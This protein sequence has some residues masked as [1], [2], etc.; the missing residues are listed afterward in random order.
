MADK[1]PTYSAVKSV[2]KTQ[3]KIQIPIWFIRQHGHEYKV[4]IFADKIVLTPTK[5]GA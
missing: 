3:N 5:K 1:N 4:E 2:K